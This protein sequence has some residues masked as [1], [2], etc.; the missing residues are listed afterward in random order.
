ME[1]TLSNEKQPPAPLKLRDVRRV[2]RLMSEIREL[3]NEPNQW[4]PLL[5]KELGKIVKAQIT[6]SAEVHFRRSKTPGMMRVVDIG[7]GGD[8]EGNVWTIHSERD[9]ERPETYWLA[10]GAEDAEG[11]TKPTDAVTRDAEDASAGPA[12]DWGKAGELITVKPQRQVYGGKSFILSQYPLP[13]AGAVDQLGLHRA[14]GDAPFTPSQHRLVHLFHVEL[15]RLWRR[16]AIRRAKDPTAD[17]PPRLSQTLA[18]LAAGCSEK[19]IAHKLQLS[20]HTVHNYVKALHQRFGVSSRGEL[21]AKVGQDRSTAAPKLSLDAGR[22]SMDGAGG[23][24]S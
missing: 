3:G 19:Q 7:W 4:R 14:F 21:L 15:G 24:Q 11:E 8:S 10:Q 23:A 13:H 16:D 17:L 1:R 12:D 2:F 22:Q 5:V 18:E 6:V 20:R 9:D